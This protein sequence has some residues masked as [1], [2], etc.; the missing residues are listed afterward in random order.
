MG[1]NSDT[2]VLDKVHGLLSEVSVVLE[3]GSTIVVV[4]LAKN[5]DVLTTSERVLED[6]SRS[7]EDIR[8]GTRGLT[9]GR[10]VK[11]PLLKVGNRRRPLVKGHGLRSEP[12]GAIDPDVCR[13]EYMKNREQDE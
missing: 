10:T 3:V 1:I 2:Y 7:E 8:V 5:E 4:A 9:G 6:G 13:N 11:V 12:V